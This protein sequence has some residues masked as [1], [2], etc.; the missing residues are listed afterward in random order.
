MELTDN[1]AL[2]VLLNDLYVDDILIGVD[3]EVDAIGLISQLEALLREGGFEPHR[4][5]SNCEGIVPELRATNQVGKS[6]V[7][8]IDAGAIKTLGLNWHPESD[9]FQFSIEPIINS[10]ATKHEVLSTISILFDPLG[11]VSPILTRAKLI[12]QETW[13]LDLG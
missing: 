8:S 4:W 10:V 3:R 6:F 12:M 11:L 7:L 1:R 5:R 9:M 2:Q 13:S